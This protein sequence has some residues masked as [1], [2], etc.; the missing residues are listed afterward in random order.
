MTEST[1]LTIVSWFRGLPPKM[2]GMIG[3]GLLAWGTAGLFIS[4]A[5]E[6]NMGFEPTEQE[7]EALR[8]VVPKISMVERD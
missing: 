4:D 6:K 3:A 5:A 2:Q 1:R 7:K 8:S